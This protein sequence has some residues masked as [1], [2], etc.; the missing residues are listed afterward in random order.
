LKGIPNLCHVDLTGTK[1]TDAGVEELKSA[2]PEL[3]IIR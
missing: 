3:Q 2:L 1:V